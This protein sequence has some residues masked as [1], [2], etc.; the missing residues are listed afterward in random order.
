MGPMMLPL[1]LLLAATSGFETVSD[2]PCTNQAQELAIVET[3]RMFPM[4]AE[5]YGVVRNAFAPRPELFMEMS[6]P[7]GWSYRRHDEWPA[8]QQFIVELSPRNEAS[9]SFAM[10]E[11]MDTSSVMLNDLVKMLV[12]MH[13]GRD[14]AHSPGPFPYT[15]FLALADR[16]DGDAVHVEAQCWLAADAAR[17]FH[18]VD[19]ANSRAEPNLDTVEKCRA[20]LATFHAWLRDHRREL[21]AG[22]DAER[23]AIADA[24]ARMGRITLCRH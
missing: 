4:T 3:L 12:Q 21:E 2:R 10:Q 9:G 24:R 15:A 6:L 20:S 22:K 13:D 5:S 7:E 19:G 11:L 8:A 17:L 18:V 23:K 16:I 1:V 14:P